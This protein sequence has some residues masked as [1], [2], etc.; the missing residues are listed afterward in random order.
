M[1]VVYRTVV[2]DSNVVVSATKGV[3]VKFVSVVLVKQL[4][5]PMEGENGVLRPKITEPTD[6]QPLITIPITPP[7]TAP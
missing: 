6:T 5:V 7:H 4:A 2:W 3:D 1:V